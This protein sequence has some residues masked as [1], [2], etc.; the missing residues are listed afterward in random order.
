MS[1]AVV[2]YHR[3]SNSYATISGKFNE[4]QTTASL[5]DGGSDTV[6]TAHRLLC[7]VLGPT[8]RF[9]QGP[10]GSTRNESHCGKVE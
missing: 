5:R 8:R 3:A 6:R 2:V 1:D 7:A 10:W 9:A 4:K